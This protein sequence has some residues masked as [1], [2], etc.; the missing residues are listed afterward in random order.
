[1]GRRDLVLR[2]D[3]PQW[4]WSALVEQYAHS[5]RSECATRSML[6]HGADLLDGDAGKPLNEL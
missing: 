1:M 3:S 4:D 6:Q 5:G 2:Q